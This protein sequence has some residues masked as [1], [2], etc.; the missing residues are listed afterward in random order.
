M[1]SGGGGSILPSVYTY[2]SNG[3]RGEGKDMV[4]ETPPCENHVGLGLVPAVPQDQLIT[5]Q[6]NRVRIGRP[7]VLPWSGARSGDVWI[8]S[9]G[10]VR[11]E[12]ALRR[13]VH[14]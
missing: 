2:P 1:G 4:P 11:R 5:D 7:F 12:G 13:A 3:Q 8:W 6:L 9:G 14:G 10:G